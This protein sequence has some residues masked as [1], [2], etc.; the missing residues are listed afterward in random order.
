MCFE[1]YIYK[2]SPKSGGMVYEYIYITSVMLD[3]VGASLSKQ[4]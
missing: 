1:V 3:I 2:L 4:M